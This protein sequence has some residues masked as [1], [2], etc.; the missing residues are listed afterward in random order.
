MAGEDHGA[1]GVGVHV[2]FGGGL[3]NGIDE[4]GQGAFGVVGV[5]VVG[6][7]EVEIDVFELTLGEIGDGAVVDERTPCLIIEE[8]AATLSAG[9]VRGGA[10]GLGFA[11]GGKT[12]GAFGGF[13]V[14][15]GG[16]HLW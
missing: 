7:D 9:F 5:G 13:A 4:G 12:G 15:A 16:G 8:V 2:V 3:E 11:R 10:A 1:P 14:A 6:V